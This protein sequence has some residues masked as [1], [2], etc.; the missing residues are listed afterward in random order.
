MCTVMCEMTKWLSY[1]YETPVKM[2]ESLWK[3]EL[4]MNINPDQ[5]S[6][7]ANQIS[8]RGSRGIEEVAEAAAPVAQSIVEKV[9]EEAPKL[10]ESILK[11]IFH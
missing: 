7:L 6:N 10:I 9:A 11:G 4:L 8:F 2:G 5:L 3:G 1:K